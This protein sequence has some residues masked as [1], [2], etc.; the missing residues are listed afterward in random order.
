MDNLPWRGNLARGWRKVWNGGSGR[1]RIR[2]DPTGSTGS[3]Q[4]RV[5]SEKNTLL[6][7]KFFLAFWGILSISYSSVLL[8]SWMSSLLLISCCE[9]RIQFRHKAMPDNDWCCWS[10]YT[11]SFIAYV[12][13][14]Q[15]A[16]ACLLVHTSEAWALFRPTAYN[17]ICKERYTSGSLVRM[18]YSFHER[19]TKI[20]N[21]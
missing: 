12:K 1:N 4:I 11:L 8:L 6:N 15:S 20:S 17:F 14:K 16:N 3:D 18:Q 5:F 2:P 9:F 10:Q 13:T 21:N 19:T 7:S